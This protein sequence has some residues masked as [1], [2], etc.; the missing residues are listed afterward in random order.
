MLSIE[1]FGF[2]G[3]SHQ[4]RHMQEASMELP[5]LRPSTSSGGDSILVI[6]E[7]SLLKKIVNV[8]VLWAQRHLL[9]E[10]MSG[11]L[12]AAEPVNQK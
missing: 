5:S 1:C 9:N 8:E 7:Q 4:Q 10:S 2:Y 11:S 12:G 6:Q 3:K